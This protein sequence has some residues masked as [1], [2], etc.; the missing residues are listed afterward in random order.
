[1]QTHEHFSGLTE[2]EVRSRKEHFGSNLL[3]TDQKKSFSQMLLKTLREPMLIL[4]L[5]ASTLYFFLGDWQ[6]AIMLSLSVFFV[7]GLSFYQQQRSTRALESLK[8]LSSPRALVV[9]GGQQKRIAASELVPDDIVILSE[10]DRIPADGVLLEANYLKVDE[11]LLTG[12]SFPVEKRPFKLLVDQEKKSSE[13]A[14]DLQ[15][16]E[17]SVFSSTL[18]ISGRAIMRVQKIGAKTE[19]G[20]IGLSLRELVPETLNLNDE[21]KQLVKIFA[22]SG[23]AISCTVILA[24]GILKHQWVEAILLGLAVQMALLPEEFPVILSIFMALGAWRLSKVKVLVRNPQAIEKLG[25]INVLCVDKTGTL[26]ENRMSIE[27]L[28]AANEFFNPQEGVRWASLYTD[29]ILQAALA[30]PKRPF[31]PMEVAISEMAQKND[32]RYTH[33]LNRGEI[34]KEFPLTDEVK[35]TTFVWRSPDKNGSGI[36]A[37]KGA[38]ESVLMN[39]KMPENDKKI[40]MSHVDRMAQRGFRVLAVAAY[41]TFQTEVPTSLREISFNY[42][43]LLGFRDPIRREVPEA[44]SLGQKAGVKVIML[45]GDHAQTAAIV[46]RKI[47]LEIGDGVLTGAELEQMN[48]QELVRRLKK[49]HVFARM[50]PRQKLRLVKLLKAQGEVVAMTGDGVND[51]PSLKWADIGISMGARGTDVARESSDIVLMDDNFVSIIAGIR[52]G[53]IIFSNI[54]KAISYVISIHVPIA[55]LALLPV[56]LKWPI[57]L[58]PAH[59]V[60]LEIIIDP[61]CSLLF[62]SLEAEDDIMS[63]PP[64]AAGSRLFTFKDYLRGILQGSVVLALL[65]LILWYLVKQKVPAQQS[66]AIIFLLLVICNIALILADLGSGSFSQI[67]IVLKKK[68]TLLAT[69]ALVTTLVFIFTNDLTKRI[70]EIGDL[71]LTEVVASIILCTFV[72]L[73]LNYWNRFKIHLKN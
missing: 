27:S 16:N 57:I 11:S 12:E 42:S 41:S 25:T 61:V 38:P 8:N 17:S 53:R 52:R 13:T 40:V 9:R 55:G 28:C 7:I 63:E 31:D 20:K 49:Q 73:T 46:A 34:L 37:M 39:C 5:I 23:F 15:S 10:G 3:P 59:I 35:A 36:I 72:F 24:T 62:E 48:D 2:L 60:L 58:M 70:F 33:F 29:L 6:E 65:T 71:A 54:R 43:G 51:A 67:K 19:V 21:I 14:V 32:T 47:G 69:I 50:I 56:F 18:V 64:R 45:T 30:C 1:M 4:L 44:V 66:R 22:V 68:T 26:T